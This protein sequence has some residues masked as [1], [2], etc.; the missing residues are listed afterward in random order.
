MTARVKLLSIAVFVASLLLSPRDAAA[1]VSP[2]PERDR[3]WQT[4][5]GITLATGA[6]TQLLMPRVFYS[7]PEVTVGW[8]A[9]WHVSV[10]APVM[11][12]TAL[13]VLNEV[14]I[15]DA[16]EGHRPGCDETNQGLPNCETY[17]MPST[18]A[19]GSMAALGHGTAVFLFDTFSWSQGRVNGYALAGNVALPFVLGAITVVGRGVGNHESA[20]QIAVGGVSGLAF[21]FLTGMAYS[22]MQRPECGYTGSLICW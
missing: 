9:R 8:R 2:V 7:D 3:T 6:A 11:T 13:T 17:G 4:V 20:G 18:H 15:K 22:L 10:L 19:F 21:G 1:Q 12:L 14:A 5:T 16:F